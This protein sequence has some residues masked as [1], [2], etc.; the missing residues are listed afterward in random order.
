M[1]LT[2]AMPPPTALSTAESGLYDGEWNALIWFFF[3]WHWSGFF[4]PPFC[5]GFSCNPRK[6]VKPS[7]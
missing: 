7:V 4:F 1:P 3:G 2:T 5:P 6:S